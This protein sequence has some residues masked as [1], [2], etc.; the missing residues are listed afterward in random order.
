MRDIFGL[1]KKSGVNFVLF[2][3]LSLTCLY[4]FLLVPFSCR[5]ADVFGLV[6]S[7]TI[8]SETTHKGNQRREQ[9]CM[10]LHNRPGV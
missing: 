9:Y 10:R 4:F 6:L 2:F 5:I 3:S 7:A 8:I 1:K